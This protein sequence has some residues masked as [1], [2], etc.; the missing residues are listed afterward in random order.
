[1][2]CCKLNKLNKG[3]RILFGKEGSF[4]RQNPEVLESKCHKTEA[5]CENGFQTLPLRE[6]PQRT[7]VKAKMN[8]GFS[9]FWH[10]AYC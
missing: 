7:Q 1:M 10:T 3:L 5:L 6:G 9:F 4:S 2:F 8:K